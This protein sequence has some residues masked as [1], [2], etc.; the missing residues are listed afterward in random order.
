M[1]LVVGIFQPFWPVFL[2]SRGL[3]GAEIGLIFALVSWLRI[4]TIPAIAQIADHGGRAKAT[5]VV[6]ALCLVVFT[7]FLNARGFWPILLV[8]LPAAVC[9]QPMIPLA[10]SQTMAAVL[11][12]RAP[13]HRAWRR[14]SIRASASARCPGVSWGLSSS[15]R[16]AD[17]RRPCSAASDS[18]TTALT[19]S[20]PTPRPRA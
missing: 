3:D 14:A 6:A 19:R 4:V 20:R 9:F 10:E 15:R 13:R 7:G 17:Q 16:P 8:L 12:D 1:F 18:Q 5:L 11:R 2:N